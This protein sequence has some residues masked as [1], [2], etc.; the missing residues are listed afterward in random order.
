[1]GPRVHQEIQAL[2]GGGR[3][4]TQASKYG[5]TGPHDDGPE[6]PDMPSTQ[7]FALAH[8]SDPHL[9]DWSVARPW[10]LANKRLSGWL[11]WRFNRSR[12]HLAHVLDLMAADIADQ[13]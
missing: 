12:I 9:A 8:L 3:G 5:Q 7:A 10:A 6:I 4:L 1:M 2:R 11:S 13:E